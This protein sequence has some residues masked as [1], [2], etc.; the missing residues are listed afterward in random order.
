MCLA[1]SLASAKDM[2]EWL[3]A[4]SHGLFNFPPGVR[5]VPL[6]IHIQGFDIVHLE[7]RMQVGD[8]GDAWVQGQ[9]LRRDGGGGWGGGGGEEGGGG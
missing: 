8:P 2:G 6:E 5:P 3:G 4:S 1:A 9:G 7:A